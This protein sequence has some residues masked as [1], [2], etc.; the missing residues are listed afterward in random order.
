MLGRT[1][2]RFRDKDLDCGSTQGGNGCGGAMVYY[3]Q[4]VRGRRGRP[5]PQD[6]G[7]TRGGKGGR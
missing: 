4:T 2:R 3:A 5:G 7:N 1:V 6:G